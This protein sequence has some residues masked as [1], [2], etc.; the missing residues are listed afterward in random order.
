MDCPKLSIILPIY[1]GEKFLTQ[2]IESVLNSTLH[3]WEL[4]LVNDGSTDTSEKICKEY[5][6]KENR[7]HYIC[8]DNLGLSAARNAG[9]SIACGTYIVYLDA[10]DYVEKD[11]YEQLVNEAEKKQADFIVT[12][13]TRE[14][15][16]DKRTNHIAKTTW[17]RHLLQSIDEIKEESQKLYF[18]NVYI[19]VWNKI[20]R[21]EKLIEHNICFDE[22]IRYGEDVPYNIQALAVTESILFLKLSG[23]HYICHNVARLTNRWNENLLNY[24][25]EIYKKI[26][27]HE[28]LKWQ[29][30][31]SNVAAGMYLRSCFLTWEKA[32]C[33]QKFD[34]QLKNAIIKQTL[35]FEETKETIDILS[36]HKTNIEFETYY[37]I[38]KTQNV[39]LIYMSVIMR[40]FLKSLLG[41]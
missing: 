16:H 12:G 30:L 29:I 8:Q 11:Y 2:A 19:H 22:N 5:C 10:D 7:I 26:R 32:T 36:K 28:Y 35:L 41:R 31:E 1:N 6:C 40:K 39:N 24:N 21:R 17:N 23:Y 25:R 3:S 9:F 37:R 20:Y 13:F 18:Y 34:Y 38:L 4:I 27:L 14:F 33:N 15:V